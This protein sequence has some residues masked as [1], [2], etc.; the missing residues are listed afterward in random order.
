MSKSTKTNNSAFLKKSAVIASISVAVLLSAIKLLAAL[1]TD[2][3]AILSSFVDSITDVASSLITLF[4][5]YISLKPANCDYRYGFGKTEAVSAILQAAFISVSAAF[6]VYDGIDRIFH[7]VELNQTG[8]GIA[9]M[10]LCMFITL[11]LILFQKMVAKKT[12]SL[13]II[14][15]SAHYTA[16]LATNF[17]IISSLAVSNYFNLYWFDTMAAVFVALYLFYQAYD[18]GKNSFYMLVDKEL[19]EKIRTDIGNLIIQTSGVMGFHDLRTRD[20][21]GKYIFEFHLEIDGNLSLYK[22]HEIAENVEKNIIKK[23]PSAQIIIHEDPFG[24]EENRLDNSLPP[25]CQKV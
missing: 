16:D 24:I 22:A 14:A 6:I 18:L 11:L 12:S 9:V 20:L 2:S 1:Y 15:D 21:G 19:D 23:Y 3:L 17:A 13:A 10:C 4:A 8:V 5:V 7:P 25:R